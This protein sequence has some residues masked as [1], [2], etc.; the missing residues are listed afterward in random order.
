MS[1]LKE[2]WH[3]Y[4]R[5]PVRLAPLVVAI[6]LAAGLAWHLTVDRGSAAARRGVLL[7]GNVGP[8]WQTTE[9]FS[10]KGKRFARVQWDGLFRVWDTT[11]GVEV[12][13]LKDP[14][15][16]VFKMVFSPDESQLAA[17]LLGNR[18]KVWDAAT[19][20]ELFSSPGPDSVACEISYSPDGRYLAC[21]D[22]RGIV[23]VLD[24]STGQAVLD[25]TLNHAYAVSVSPDCSRLALLG[26]DGAWSVWDVATGQEA[27]RHQGRAG[28]I[29]RT[30]HSPDGQ[31]LAVSYGDGGVTVLNL[32]TG[33]EGFRRQTHVGRVVSMSYT[34]DG[35]RL[36]LVD[37]HPVQGRKE[38]SGQTVGVEV[39]E[40]GSGRL[41]FTL[42]QQ[43]GVA[44]SPDGGRVAALSSEKALQVWDVRAGKVVL[45]AAEEPG[46]YG[47]MAFSPSGERLAVTGR[48]GMRVWDTVAGREVLAVE[49]PAYGFG[50]MRLENQLV[51]AS[52]RLF[53]PVLP[54]SITRFSP[55]GKRLVAVMGN[56]M[57]EDKVWDAATGRELISFP[58]AIAAHGP[59]S[60]DL[61][62]KA[63]SGEDGAVQVWD[64]TTGRQVVAFIAAQSE[65]VL[66]SFSP[67]GTY[68]VAQWGKNVQ[69]WD[70]AAGREILSFTADTNIA[71]EDVTFSPDGKHLIA[72]WANSVKVWDL[73]RIAGP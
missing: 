32:A 73:G 57:L 24:A 13:S 31:W 69:V 72:R 70:V 53:G 21:W 48:N 36:V 38:H 39:W 28:R 1:G 45:S 15:N 61:K 27:H 65:V 8:V 35:G 29:S 49:N 20:Q 68:L 40:L 46:G 5:D 25:F 54:R 23:K 14:T 11:T 16:V 37:H 2:L 51:H 6:L 42:T 62:Y 58:S 63:T 64:L 55:D 59:F 71:Y 12:L 43:T 26:E 60:P 30:V 9:I 52:I 18:V 17:A 47:E 50:N 56:A 66:L 19:G 33:Q 3:R 4:R 67:D 10:A 44:V 7:Q 34:P 22:N 41:C